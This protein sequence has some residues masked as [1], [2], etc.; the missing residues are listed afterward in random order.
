MLFFRHLPKEFTNLMGYHFLNYWIVDQ[1]WRVLDL[2]EVRFLRAE[3]H[4]T[5]LL[6]YSF[7]GFDRLY[8]DIGTICSDFDPQGCFVSV[9]IRSIAPD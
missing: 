3:V 8:Q 1:R 6:D 7:D 4:V 5:L 2:L 9:S